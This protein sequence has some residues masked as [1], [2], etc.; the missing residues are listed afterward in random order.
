MGTI[1]AK[2]IRIPH[3]PWSTAGSVTVALSSKQYRPSDNERA[4]A[5]MLGVFPFY[6]LQYDTADKQHH[7]IVLA[8]RKN[9][10]VC[11]PK[12]PTL[13]PKSQ[14]V[15]FSIVLKSKKRMSFYENEKDTFS[16]S[17]PLPSG[18]AGSFRFLSLPRE[19][20]RK[21]FHPTDVRQIELQFRPAI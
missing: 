19:G 9:C 11:D 1:G 5:A 2:S 7:V 4:D 3:S 20:V 8:N 10:E 17:G 15:R 12:L 16:G 18:K 6:F 21:D 14:L 13:D